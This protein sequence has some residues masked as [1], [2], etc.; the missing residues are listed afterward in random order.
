MLLGVTLVV[1]SLLGPQQAVVS[2]PLGVRAPDIT[3]ALGLRPVDQPPGEGVTLQPR[4]ISQA[5][6]PNNDGWMAASIPNGLGL[7]L[8][9]QT[10]FS[11]PYRAQRLVNF[12]EATAIVAI[13]AIALFVI[14]ARIATRRRVTGV[15]LVPPMVFI[16]VSAAVLMTSA[17]K[18]L[19]WYAGPLAL[20]TC[21]G[22]SASIAGVV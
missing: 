10:L 4:D 2:Q 6:T 20:V 3:G 16:A 19:F 15:H 7:Q 14:A 9:P 5:I 17:V 22:I 8:G 21:I 11:M 18:P 13:S 12:A 1:V